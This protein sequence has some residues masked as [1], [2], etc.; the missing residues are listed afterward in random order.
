MEECEDERLG[1]FPSTEGWRH[2]GLFSRLLKGLLPLP[3]ALRLEPVK[4]A[5]PMPGQPATAEKKT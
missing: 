1:G 2:G 5:I 4:I 3:G